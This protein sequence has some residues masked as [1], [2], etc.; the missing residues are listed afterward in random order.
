MYLF[1]N[2][3]DVS[4]GARARV[5]CN[6]IGYTLETLERTDGWTYGRVLLHLNVSLTH[7]IIV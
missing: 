2:L 3:S 1:F 5:V 4:P 6:K 7:E